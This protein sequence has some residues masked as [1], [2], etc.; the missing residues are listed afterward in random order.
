MLRPFL[1]FFTS[2]LHNA[3]AVY[4][5]IV[6]Y[7]SILEG[8]IMQIEK[9]EQYIITRNTIAVFRLHDPVYQSRVLEA[10]KEILVEQ[11]PLSIIDHSCMQYGSSY[12]GRVHAIGR[13]LRTDKKVPI[14]VHPAHGVFMLP[15]SS[16][17][18][19]NCVW[20]SFYHI[21]SYKETKSRTQVSF[22]NGTALFVETSERS[23]DQQYKRTG[24]VIAL[25]NNE[26]FFMGQSLS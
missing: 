12:E 9:R 24:T 21:Q 19:T 7:Q 8:E 15:T 11:S 20:L 23:F 1:L 3:V 18:N 13:L 26:H 4:S 16:P 2:P 17:T 5:N 10:D 22:Y 14:P 6:L 25:L